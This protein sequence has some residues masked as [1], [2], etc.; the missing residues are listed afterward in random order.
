MGNENSGRYPR[1]TLQDRRRIIRRVADGARTVE[2]ATEV[3]RSS[4]FVQRVIREAGGVA[5]R[6]DQ[7][8][9]VPELSGRTVNREPALDAARQ[10]GVPIE[11]LGDSSGRLD[12]LG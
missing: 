12:L 5:R 3:A 9:T 8:R 11:S 1:L 7:R 4:S 2:V 10:V 6:R